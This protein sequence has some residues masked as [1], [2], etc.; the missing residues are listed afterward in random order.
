VGL[1]TWLP[2]ARRPGWVSDLPLLFSADVSRHSTELHHPSNGRRPQ[3]ES[4][5][6]ISWSRK[7]NK[8]LLDTSAAFCSTSRNF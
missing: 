6:Q 1:A 5:L 2:R 3:A 8:I 7:E 4:E